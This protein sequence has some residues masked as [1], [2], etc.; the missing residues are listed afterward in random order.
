MK[1][2]DDRDDFLQITN[3]LISEQRFGEA[4][5][6]LQKIIDADKKNKKA[7][8]LKEQ[9]QKILEYLNRDLFGST[10]LD[11]DPWLE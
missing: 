1:K 7:I 2:A 10:N 3:K 9:I 5:N 6:Y 11:M 4:I 8:A